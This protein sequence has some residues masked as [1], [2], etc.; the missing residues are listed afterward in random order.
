[1]LEL[2]AHAAMTIRRSKGPRLRWP[3]GKR[4]AFYV[5]IN[6]EHFAFRAGLGTDPA[7]RGG[8]QTTRNYA[9][10]DYGMRV[11]MFR[12]FGILD[13]LRLPATI[14]LNSSVCENYP[15]IVERIK[16]RGDEC[17][18]MAAPM[19]KSSRGM[20]EHDEARV[21]AEIHRDDRASIR[22]CGRPAGWGRARR[23]P[24]SPP[25]SSRRP[26]IP[27]TSTGR[28]TT[29]R[30]GCGPAPG[31]SCRCP[32]PWSSTTWARNVNRDHTGREF[33]EMIVDQFDEMV[34]QSAEQPLVM[35]VSLHGFIV[36]QPFRLRP[37]RQALTHCVEHKLKDRVWYTRA[38][39]IANYCLTLPPG[40]DARRLSAPPQSFSTRSALPC[41]NF[42]LS[43][44]ASG[45][46]FR[47]SMPTLFEFVGPVDREQHVV[48]AHLHH[49]AEERGDGEIA[50][51]G[52]D[53]IL[54]EI[55]PR[56]LLEAAR[57]HRE[58]RVVVEPVE[59]ERQA[60][61][62]VAEDEFEP[63]IGVEHAR[64]RRAAGNA[65]RSPSRS[66]RPRSAAPR[67]PRNRP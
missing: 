20:W 59:P 19:P 22:A 27:T 40:I 38:L 48:D 2:P 3:G 56:R 55:L 28:S 36:G 67:S 60:L 65:C 62:H 44:S 53:E 7:N 13:E 17:S 10:R 30:S 57:L 46:C 34:E 58:V 42:S 15:E 45:R 4:L 9:W 41:A 47:N 1:M 6:I 29:S 24:A 43:A 64:R 52:D 14:L 66:P 26:A 23:N 31:R 50:A 39:D 33:A 16:A 51:A 21:I 35:A 49:R 32:I 54:G 37:L 61:A 8:P 12:M 11:G 5:A 63:R 18:A 25:I